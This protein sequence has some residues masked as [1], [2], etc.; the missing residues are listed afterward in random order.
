VGADRI[1]AIVRS[2]GETVSVVTRFCFSRHIIIASQKYRFGRVAAIVRLATFG[3][4]NEIRYG[5]FT[6]LSEQVPS[7]MAWFRTYRGVVAWLAF[8]ALACQLS[9][10]FGHIHISKFGSG[11]VAPVAVQTT[12]VTSGAEPSPQ[13]P[14]LVSVDF[15]AVCAS[16]SLAS[17]LILPI[18]A[19]ILAPDLFARILQWPLAACEP[20][21][22][23][24]RPFRARAPPHA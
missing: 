21:S 11:P 17:A 20:A 6:R 2:A 15:C 14:A 24:H 23:G 4:N 16:I 18:L 3:L 8:F 12:D 13:N 10:S 22:F 1:L 9:F 5:I 19:F 7:L